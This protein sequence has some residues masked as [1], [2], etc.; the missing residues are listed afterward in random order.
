MA[1]GPRPRALARRVPAVHDALPAGE[2]PAAELGAGV[3]SRGTHCRRTHGLPRR[4]QV[5]VDAGPGH[6]RRRAGG[7]QPDANGRL[8]D[9]EGRFVA[10]GKA[11]GAGYGKNAGKELEV[12]LGTRRMSPADSP[13]QDPP[14]TSTTRCWC[15]GLTGTAD[16]RP[17]RSPAPSRNWPKDAVE[18][19]YPALP[20]RIPKRDG[21]DDPVGVELL[22]GV[23]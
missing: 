7:V 18:V 5:R 1:E 11:A 12:N 21:D 23:R 20:G 19:P 22:I 14:P 16:P 6:L 17:R 8:H 2:A 13:R 9:L 10:E 4:R 3:S 15:A